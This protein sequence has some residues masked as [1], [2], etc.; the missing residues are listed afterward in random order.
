MSSS[1]YW[2]FESLGIFYLIHGVISLVVAFTASYFLHRRFEN[3]KATIMLLFFM[4]NISLPGVGYLFTIWVVYYLL[5]VQYETTLNSANY[6]NMIEFE[7]E[8]PEIKR[9]FGVGSMSELLTN[10]V[11]PTPLK[12]KALVSLADNITQNNVTLIKNSLSDTNDEIRL[13]SFAIIDNMERGINGKIHSKLKEFQE[14]KSS[15]IKIGLAEELTYLYWDMIYFQ[16]SDDDL[17]KYMLN[18]VKKY[19]QIVLKAELYHVKINVI[20]GKVYL[21]EKKF[22]DAATCFT[23]AIEQDGETDY[24]LP[25]LAEIFYN[26][27]NFR[28]VKSLLNSAKN[29]KMNATLYP[30]VE[31]WKSS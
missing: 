5:N 21:M 8:F 28:S 23:M 22:D 4:F 19:A 10:D 12:M 30:V 15:A 29:L 6:I 20:L 27:K 9:V 31:Q 18:E 11:A 7:S 17:K 13:F 26:M 14:A 1:E 24:T 2:I 16:L 3:Q 25:Y